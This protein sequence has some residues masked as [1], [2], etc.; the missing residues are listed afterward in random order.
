MLDVELL[1]PCP[2]PVLF[3]YH[4]T[5]QCADGPEK[6][7]E[8]YNDL[9]FGLQFLLRIVVG[10]IGLDEKP[11]LLVG[12]AQLLDYYPLAAVAPECLGYGIDGFGVYFNGEFDQIHI[13]SQAF[14]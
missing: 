9:H 5:F 11:Y 12:R 13:K 3:L 8:A 2:G 4:P 6:S 1:A 10:G 14:G 7:Q